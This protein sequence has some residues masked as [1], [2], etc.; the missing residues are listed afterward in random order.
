VVFLKIEGEEA[1]PEQFAQEF[2]ARYE[3]R[4]DLEIFRNTPI[5][6]GGIE[7]WRVAAYGTVDGSRKAGQ[8]TF[9]PY[10][11]L[12]YRITAVAPKRSAE[13]YLARVRNTVRS[14]RPMDEEARGGFTMM[15]LR[16]VR[17]LPGETIPEIMK[18]TGSGLRPSGVAAA[19]G[20]FIDHRFSGGELV[21]IAAVEPY[22]PPR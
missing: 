14:F 8:L 12:M 10:N 7:S 18:R 2:I 19:N 15:R 3:E 5:I 1:D 13:K 16:I 11:G 9:I 20:V 22:E 21:K 4:F 6:I 17:A